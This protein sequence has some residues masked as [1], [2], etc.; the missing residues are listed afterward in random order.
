MTLHFYLRYSTRFG[1]SLFVSGNTP[2]LGNNDI[3]KRFGL[4][5]LNNQLWYGT[6]EI[7][8]KDVF[9]TIC[10]RYILLD[11]DGELVY[12]FGNDRIIEIN[13]LKGSKIVLY[14]TWNHAGQYENV[15]YTAPFAYVLLKHKPAKYAAEKKPAKPT[16]EFRVKAPLLKPH[17][18][19]CVSGSAAVMYNWDK[20]DVLLLS[21][22]DTWFTIELDLSQAVFPLEY[23]YG[24]YDTVSKKFISFEE[25]NNRVLLSEDGKDALTIVHDGFAKLNNVNWKGAAVAIPVFSLRSKSSFGTGEFTDLKLLIDWAKTVGLK[26]IQLLP[27]N[28]T[29]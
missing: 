19:I 23:K 1:Q 8:A 16:H 3:K 28:D 14:D 22:K 5:Y 25:G 29:T 15:F 2:L 24:I 18:I 20:E 27:V 6:L 7:D 17:E 26:M 11:E 10:Y 4:T 21:K 13:D 12:E 9:E